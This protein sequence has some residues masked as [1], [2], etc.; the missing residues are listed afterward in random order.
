MKEDEP[1]VINNSTGE[2]ELGDNSGIDDVNIK[3]LNQNVTDG[4]V[5]DVSNDGKYL[6]TG[7]ITGTVPDSSKNVDN[8]LNLNLFNIKNNQLKQILVSSKEQINGLIDSIND[9]IFYVE[10]QKGEDGKPVPD[11]YTLNWSNNDGT[12]TKKIS[13]PDENVSEKF[14][15]IDDVLIYGNTKG[16]IKLLDINDIAEKNVY[17]KTYQLDSSNTM[18][19]TKIQ[20]HKR[21]NKA[22]FL[23]KNTKT[24]TTDFYVAQL[25]NYLTKPNKIEENV[26]DFQIAQNEKGVL[27]CIAGE[28]NKLVYYKIQLVPE[29]KVLYEGAVNIFSFSPDEKTILFS[30]RLDN[31][32]NAQNIWTMNNEG[33]NLKLVASNYKIT[34]NRILFHPDKNMI[35]FSVSTVS[36]Q[37][38]N[39]YINKVYMI[40][41]TY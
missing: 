29:R 38:P 34:G 11:S 10:Y 3:N 17:S 23:V 19:I 31:T 6:L 28:K 8:T 13:G 40:E 18:S 30:E 2:K 9:G 26:T 32:S 41:Y 39:S 14:Y 24:N 5:Y 12:I 15:V 21:L 4:L 1:I 16:Q 22:F 27:Y 35:Y 7:N 36:D 37:D 25:D 33:G 20:Y